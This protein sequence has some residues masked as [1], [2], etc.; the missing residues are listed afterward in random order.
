MNDVELDKLQV[1][2]VMLLQATVDEALA[3][4]SQLHYL[5]GHLQ[6]RLPK[7]PQTDLAALF[8]LAMLHLHRNV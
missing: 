2:L 1:L 7:R 5:L 4:T 3:V 8:L 6:D